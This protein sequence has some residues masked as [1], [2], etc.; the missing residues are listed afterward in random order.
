MTLVSQA[1]LVAGAL[2]GQVVSFPTDTVP[3][4]AVLPE[5]AGLIFALKKRPPHKPLIL[6][7][8]TADELWTYTSGTAAEQQIWQQVA[9]QYWPGALT[10]VLPASS[11]LP[12]AINPCHSATIAVRVP[13]DD[14]A[15]TI[16]AQTGPLA[17]TSANLSG[18]PPLETMT[19]IEAKFPDILI[20]DDSQHQK[21]RGCGLPST[22]AQWTGQE[23]KILRQG[24]IRAIEIRR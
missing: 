11:Q 9:R 20:L 19:A 14:L 1:D 16:L 23:W 21:K 8:A 18:E 5:C 15:L 10:L 2:A 4:L 3:A 6:M 24:G 22:L 13:S 17:T 12:A 7:A